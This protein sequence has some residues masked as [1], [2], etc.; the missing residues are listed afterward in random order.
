[1]LYPNV[2]R[3]VFMLT[4][5]DLVTI[6]N[7]SDVVSAIQ[8]SPTL[9]LRIFLNTP[10]KEVSEDSVEYKHGKAVADI[11]AIKKE[12]SENKDEVSEVEPNTQNVNVVPPA[13]SPPIAVIQPLMSQSPQIAAQQQVPTN[14][15]QAR[16]TSPP[17]ARPEYSCSSWCCFFVVVL[18][19]AIVI[20]LIINY[21]H[22]SGHLWF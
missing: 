15:P 11:G 14:P 21:S 13:P 18:V 6:S 5:G 19:I 1:M 9:K 17:Q 8:R 4:D 3:G 10:K 2:N 12:L 16:P 22:R 20:V 7:S